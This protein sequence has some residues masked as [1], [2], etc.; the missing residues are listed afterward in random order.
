MGLQSKYGKPAST[1]ASAVNSDV[2]IRFGLVGLLAYWS[3][4][5][6]APF[7][8]IMLWSAILTVALY[9]LF[10]RLARRLGHRWLAAVLIT[11]L[12]LLIILAPVTW[13][14]FGLISGVEFLTKELAT[15]LPSPPE[16]VKDWPIVGEHIFQ[17][18]SSRRHW[19]QS[20]AG[21][22][23]TT[24]QARG[25]QTAPN[26]FQRY[27]WSPP[28]P[29]LHS[30]CRFLVLSRTP[31]SRW[32]YP[33]HGARISPAWQRD[34]AIGRRYRTQRVTWNYWNFTAAI[35]P[36]WSR[37]SDCRYSSRWPLGLRFPGLSRCSDRTSSRVSAYHHLELDFY[38]DGERFNVHSLHDPGWPTRQ[39]PKASSDGAWLRHA[40]ASDRHWSNWRDDSIRN[41]WPIFWAYC[42]LRRMEVDNR[43]AVW[44]RWQIRETSS[45]SCAGCNAPKS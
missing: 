27:G 14:G 6:I 12:C 2:A 15:G 33:I 24:A 30:N 38:V 10:D 43:L 36:G 35:F 7:L 25:H 19:H 5:V 37:L 9:P 20:T 42:S 8:T 3:W 21:R 16:F 22:A 1:A 13:L 45:K 41:H 17:A 44:G 28:I 11:L 23:G 29:G 40:D 32:A 18:W 4:G 31:I 39:S 34:G 26:R